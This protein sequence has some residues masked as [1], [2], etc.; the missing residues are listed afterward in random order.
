M[1]ADSP[2]VYFPP[3]FIYVL[4]FLTGFL[5]R[6]W[7]P[8]AIPFPR[9]AGTA[10]IALGAALAGWGIVTMWLARTGI[11][12][13]KPA[14]MLV[15]AG[16]FRWSRNPLYISLT[17]VYIGVALWTGAM[18]ALVLLPLVIVVVHFAVIRR[19][20]A[21]LARRFGDDYEDYR[22]RVRRWI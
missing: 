13:H 10:V 7:L 17:L 3:P 6:R 18:T 21:Y 5:T 22:R 19:E 4:F 9:A 2:G 16:P 14:T 8:M 1:K 15:D 20:E 11:V 12:P